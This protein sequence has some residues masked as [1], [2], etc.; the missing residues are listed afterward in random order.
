MERGGNGAGGGAGSQGL[1]VPASWLA[2]RA[3][4]GA[5]RVPHFADDMMDY[6]CHYRYSQRHSVTDKTAV[7][8][9]TEKAAIFLPG[10]RGK[11]SRRCPF[12]WGLRYHTGP[13]PTIPPNALSIFLCIGNVPSAHLD[14][15]GQH[16]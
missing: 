1:S 8:R 11:S 15:K 6:P 9:H 2:A 12:K 13:D 14:E 10:F 3:G 4:E 16:V 5:G 7:L